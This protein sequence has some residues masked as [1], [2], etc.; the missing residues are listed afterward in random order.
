[1]TWVTLNTKSANRKVGPI[2]VS[3]SDTDTCPKE[4]SLKDGDCYAR[5]GP[6]GMH[7]RKIGSDGRGDNWIGF[8]KRIMS[9]ASGTLWRHNQAGDL[10]KHNGISDDIDRL[11]DEKCRQL[12]EAAK[13]TNGWTYSHYDVTDSHNRETIKEMNSKPGMVVNLSSDSLT[14]ADEYANMDIGPVITLVP[15]G[16]DP[17]GIRTPEGRVVSMCPAQTQDDMSCD[18]CKLCAKGNRKSVVGF[19]PHGP[20]QKRLSNILGE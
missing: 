16:T 9:L 19:Y 18:R 6:L 14:Q 8:C 10:P 11:D 2:P 1:M 13:D 5:F 4:C 20:A 3:T 15:L 12:S 7:W 17:L